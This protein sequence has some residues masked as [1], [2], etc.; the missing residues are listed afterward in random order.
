MKI[1]KLIENIAIT[2]KLAFCWIVLVNF[3]IQSRDK[4]ADRVNETVL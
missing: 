4:C 2:T 3:K 1:K